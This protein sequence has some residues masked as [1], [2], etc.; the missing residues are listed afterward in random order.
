MK[1]RMA[2]DAIEKD[3]DMEEACNYINQANQ[4]R[5]GFNS[6]FQVTIEL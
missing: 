3:Q 5:E 4:I 6:W 1:I 2:K